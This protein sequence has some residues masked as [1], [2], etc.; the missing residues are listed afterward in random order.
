ME[1][2]Q[3]TAELSY[4]FDFKDTEKW[5]QHLKDE[6]FA[7]VGGLVSEADCQKAVSDMKKCLSTLSPKLTEDEETWSQG[8][9][10]PFMLEGGMVQYIGH[11]KFQWEL[12]EKVAPI[13]SK[14][15]DCEVM[16]LATSFDGFCFMNGKRGYE[17]KH[18]V[19]SAHVDQ[20]PL[21]DFLRYKG[22]SKFSREYKENF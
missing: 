8:E 18:P 3:T 9:N 20:S 15:W 2:I 19:Q 1:S 12:R 21:R 5:L 10:Y 14:I 4:R 6:G 16:N 11:A 17:P 22:P 13:F 7:V